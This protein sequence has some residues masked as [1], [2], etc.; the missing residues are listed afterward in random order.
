MTLIDDLLGKLSKDLESFVAL[1]TEETNA[2]ASGD[3]DQLARLVATRQ[4]L[5][6]G[7]AN[8]WKSLAGQLGLAPQ[9]GFAGL[10]DKA[11]S[12]TSATSAWR[13]VEELAREASHLNQVNGRLIEEQ[14]RRNQA[15][16]QVLQSAAANRGLYGSDGRVTDFLNVNRSID[17]A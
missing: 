3:P 9:T 10:R 15:A 8:H 12:V 1:L 11:L 4:N 2:L 5:S 16:I 13:R 7:I 17:T 6:L 14:L